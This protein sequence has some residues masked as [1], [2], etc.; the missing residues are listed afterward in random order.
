ME[1]KIIKL[2]SIQ[3]S[4]PEIIK[5]HGEF[6][7]RLQDV[8]KELLQSLITFLKIFKNASDELEGDKKPTIQKVVLF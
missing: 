1:Y 2:E 7:C 4:L 6:F 3:K 8:N 5:I